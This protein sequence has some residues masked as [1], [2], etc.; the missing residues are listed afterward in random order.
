MYTH[1]YDIV[2][3]YRGVYTVYD[4]LYIKDFI[5]RKS[6]ACGLSSSVIHGWFSTILSVFIDG[7]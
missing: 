1:L 3:L 7:G 2:L 6:E 4:H 5:G